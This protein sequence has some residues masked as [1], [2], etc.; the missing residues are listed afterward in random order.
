RGRPW[1][2]AR[3]TGVRF[4][5]R[6]FRSLGFASR[7]LFCSCSALS[8]PWVVGA[9]DV[10]GPATTACAAEVTAD[11]T[12]LFPHFIQA[13]LFPPYSRGT[14]P[15]LAQPGHVTVIVDT[16]RD[17]SS[18]SKDSRAK[19]LLDALRPCHGVAAVSMTSPSRNQTMI[20]PLPFFQWY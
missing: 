11:T 17:S 15:L 8:G 7:G 20:N 4:A 18:N 2:G 13:M 19:L 1:S 14:G 10:A 16:V 5:A 3:A 6:R 9:R 12:K